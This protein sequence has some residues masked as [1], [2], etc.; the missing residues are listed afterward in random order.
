MKIVISD[1]SNI[2]P[3]AKAIA[4]YPEIAPDFITID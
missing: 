4:D 1:K 3:L 2:E